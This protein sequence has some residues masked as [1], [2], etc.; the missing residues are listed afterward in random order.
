MW[1][2]ETLSLECI[3][4]SSVISSLF[5]SGHFGGYRLTLLWKVSGLGGDFGLAPGLKGNPLHLG[6]RTSPLGQGINRFQDAIRLKRQ[7]C[8]NSQFKQEESILYSLYSC[9]FIMPHSWFYCLN[10]L[11]LVSVGTVNMGQSSLTNVFPTTAVATD[12]Q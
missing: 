11:Q 1:Y 12:S 2:T 9:G 7:R 4:F 8:R 10:M 6:D 3:V 5:K